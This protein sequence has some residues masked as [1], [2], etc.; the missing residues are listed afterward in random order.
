MGENPG[1]L[2]DSPKSHEFGYLTAH[3]LTY[4][5][6]INESGSRSSKVRRP[7]L[8]YSSLGGSQISFPTERKVMTS[9]EA[10]LDPDVFSQ[11][12]AKYEPDGYA[13]WVKLFAAFSVCLVV[14]GIVAAGLAFMLYAGFYFIVFV[15]MLAALGCASAMWY[16]VDISDCRSTF[17]AGVLGAVV[18]LTSYVGSY[19]ASMLWVAGFE[20]AHRID[21]LPKYIALRWKH[22]TVDDARELHGDNRARFQRQRPSTLRFWANA[23]LFAF[24]ASITAAFGFVISRRAAMRPYCPKHQEWLVGKKSPV[25][26]SPRALGER[27]TIQS[28]LANRS[29]QELTLYHCCNAM[30]GHDRCPI[31]LSATRQV[32]SSSPAK[33]ADHVVDRVRLHS[34]EEQEFAV[35]LPP[36]RFA[37]QSQDVAN[38]SDRDFDLDGTSEVPSHA[39]G[40]KPRLATVG[41][42]E[43]PWGGQ[44]TSPRQRA[45]GTAICCLPILTLIGALAGIC[46]PLALKHLGWAEPSAWWMLVGFA[47][48]PITHFCCT[49]IS[50]VPYKRMERLAKRKFPGRRKALVDFSNPDLTFALV[51]P[52]HEIQRNTLGKWDFGFLEVDANQHEIR[53][54]GDLERYRVPASS[55][56]VLEIEQAIFCASEGSVSYEYMV[57]LEFQ[58]ETG[59]VERLFSQR[60]TWRA[61]SA[62][63]IRREVAAKLHDYLRTAIDPQETSKQEHELSFVIDT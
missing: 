47:L 48:L 41:A 40:Y 46:G 51:I 30:A 28:Q 62:D 45:I 42:V 53:F 44:L 34:N 38:R 59:P 26:I 60:H 19:H 29:V 43:P 57:R 49:R 50:T 52:R 11:R 24:E 7:H 61:M 35:L 31:F 14:S 6:Q 18:C 10:Y 22:D 9:Y 25:R 8:A 37:R 39:D 20:H 27:Q 16:A 21:L 63:D 13:D 32:D 12:R 1:A 2:D 3:C 58:T 15:P 4:Q 36:D 5:T 23:V 17:I 56:T 33:K 54:E 55:I